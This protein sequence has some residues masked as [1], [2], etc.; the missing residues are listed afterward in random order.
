MA[1]MPPHSQLFP[2]V[3]VSI[4]HVLNFVA[5]LVIPVVFIWHFEPH[6]MFSACN[7]GLTCIY[8]FKVCEC[9]HI[10]TQIHVFACVGLFLVC[11]CV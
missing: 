7:L 6:P 1:D 8:F 9:L 5:L 10:C 11:G 4:G 2:S 3:L